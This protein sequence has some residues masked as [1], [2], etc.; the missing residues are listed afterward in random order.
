MKKENCPFCGHRWIRKSSESMI[1]CPNC[2]AAYFIH[3]KREEQDEIYIE[4][5]E[6]DLADEFEERNI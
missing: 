4:E 6:E 3:P 1:E 5:D 2:Q